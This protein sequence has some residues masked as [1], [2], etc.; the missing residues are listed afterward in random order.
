M[1]R[2][3]A[4]APAGTPFQVR[5][6]RSNLPSKNMQTSRIRAS[7]AHVSAPC[8]FISPSPPGCEN[9]TCA[10]VR[11]IGLPTSEQERQCARTEGERIGAMKHHHAI[12]TVSHRPNARGETMPGG[13]LG[14]RAVDQRFNQIDKTTWTIEAALGAEPFL[15]LPCKAPVRYETRRPRLHA[16]G[17]A[18]IEDEGRPPG[19]GLTPRLRSCRHSSGHARERSLRDCPHP[20]RGWRR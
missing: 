7:A 17:P 6:P 18:G 1:R 9:G 4:V 20:P 13:R 2:E 16:D 19:Q 11:I 10:P 3:K 14:I 5:F 12:D 15:D 8:K